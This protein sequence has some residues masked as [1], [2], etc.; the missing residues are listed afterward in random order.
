MKKYFLITAIIFPLLLTGN[1][2]QAQDRQTPGRTTY[3]K[4]IFLENLSAD[5]RYIG[6]EYADYLKT[7]NSYSVKGWNAYDKGLWFSK[8]GNLYG[9]KKQG[10]NF[11]KLLDFKK[12]S[13]KNA[14]QVDVCGERGYLFTD[15]EDGDEYSAVFL[16]VNSNTP[17]QKIST[18]RANNRSL[19]M[20]NGNNH[21]AYASAKA[22][23]GV[24]KLFHQETCAG[25]K[26]TKLYEGRAPVYP[27]DFHP[28]DTHL[29]ADTPFRNGD[30]LSEYDLSTGTEKVLLT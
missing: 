28:D 2:S 23:S 21:V 18:G 14:K 17:P 29:L 19:T 10:K 1:I 3:G 20:S 7:Q 4:H 11:T 9:S 15:D 5:I 22:R 13:I 30:K 16:A 27:K 26:T 24:W 8:S 25:K 6:E 12:H